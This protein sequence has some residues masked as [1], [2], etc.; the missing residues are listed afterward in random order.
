MKRKPL[1]TLEQMLAAR[2]E[3]CNVTQAQVAQELG[4][5]S[6]QY[7]SNMERGL[8]HLPVKHFRKVSQLLGVPMRDMVDHRIRD[9]RHKL[10]QQVKLI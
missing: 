7:I 5:S 8:T 4:F 1:I 3:K 9:E 2:R 10:I 6:P